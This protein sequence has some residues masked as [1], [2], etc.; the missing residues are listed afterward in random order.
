MD[1]QDPSGEQAQGA[2]G[3]GEEV[4]GDVLGWRG[5]GQSAACLCY[6]MITCICFFLEKSVARRSC[7]GMRV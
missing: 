6:L 7:L 3:E 1:R 5:R 2:M 4:L